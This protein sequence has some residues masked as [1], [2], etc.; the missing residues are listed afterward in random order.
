MTAPSAPYWIFMTERVGGL[1]ILNCW[2]VHQQAQINLSVWFDSLIWSL[3]INAHNLS[4][5]LDYFSFQIMHKSPPVTY[6]LAPLDHF[7]ARAVF[8][9]KPVKS[10]DWSMDSLIVLTYYKGLISLC[11]DGL[12]WSPWNLKLLPQRRVTFWDLLITK[13]RQMKSAQ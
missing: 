5:D 10:P 13:C 12:K 9:H 2:Q 6:R 7:S 1:T 11:T 4:R 8:C 3:F